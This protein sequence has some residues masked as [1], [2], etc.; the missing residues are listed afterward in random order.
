MSCNGGRLP[1]KACS[2]SSASLVHVRA[3]SLRMACT[4][5]FGIPSAIFSHSAAR[6]LQ[7]SEFNTAILSQN[8][9]GK[10]NSIG[11]PSSQA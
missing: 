2:A 8:S 4:R 6:I 9:G 1:F 10:A 3:I 11:P 7:S 5:G